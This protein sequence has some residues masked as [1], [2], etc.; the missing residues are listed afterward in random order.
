V[1]KDSAVQRKQTNKQASSKQNS[2]R[3]N[4]NIKLF[5]L[6]SQ[7]AALMSN[8][9]NP[10]PTL[11]MSPSSLPGWHHRYLATVARQRLLSLSSRP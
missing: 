7:L 8:Q 10:Q 3:L 5:H 9:T 11:A 1:Q 6:L 2:A 4:I